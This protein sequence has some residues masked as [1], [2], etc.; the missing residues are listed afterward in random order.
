VLVSIGRSVALSEAPLVRTVRTIS[1]RSPTP[2]WTACL[3]LG[4]HT[5]F[6]NSLPQAK[7]RGRH[8]LQALDAAAAQVR[9]SGRWYVPT[10][11]EIPRN[12]IC[13]LLLAAR[14]SPTEP[15]SRRTLDPG[16]FSDE[17]PPLDL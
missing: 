5:T 11:V 4:A 2:G 7:E 15:S 13:R 16:F 8:V 3:G 14:S 10:K 1:C 17:A 12:K 6:T 9:R